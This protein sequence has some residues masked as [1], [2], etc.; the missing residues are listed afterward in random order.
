VSLGFRY[1]RSRENGIEKEMVASRCLRQRTGE[2]SEREMFVKRE[3]Y[4]YSG[5]YT[6]E[7]PGLKVDPVVV[8]TLSVVFIFSVVALHGMHIMTPI[9]AASNKQQS[10]QRSCVDSPHS[11]TDPTAFPLP[12][13]FIAG[14]TRTK[15]PSAL[16]H[17]HR[18]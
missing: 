2:R 3:A 12:I 11:L 13:S 4:E 5:L 7:S 17:G 16:R 10:S 14:G 9:T 15:L 18:L 1:G 6:D 8:M